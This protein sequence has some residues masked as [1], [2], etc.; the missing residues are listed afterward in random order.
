ML[1]A[2][3]WLRPALARRMLVGVPLVTAVIALA[4][5]AA[6][7]APTPSMTT[8]TRAPALHGEPVLAAPIG[9]TS[10][11]LGSAR[12][13]TVS[14]GGD[15]AS[16]IDSITWRSWGGPTA[17][18]RGVGCYVPPGKPIASCVRRPVEVIAT[19]LGT[20]DGRRAYEDL[21]WWFPTEGQVFDAT[22][23]FYLRGCVYAQTI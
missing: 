5:C 14:G 9:R 12:P 13:R 19:R 7:P 16:A 11:G 4:G 18:G 3:A 20:C 2:T 1:S 15:P 10:I 17:R 21:G 22:A 23:D 8:G 6:R